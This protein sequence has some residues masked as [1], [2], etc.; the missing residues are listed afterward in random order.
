MISDYKLTDDDFAQYNINV[1][2]TGSAANWSKTKEAKS[3]YEHFMKA[4]RY[5]RALEIAVKYQLLNRIVQVEKTASEFY[6]KYPNISEA[7]EYKDMKANLIA[8]SKNNAS[9]NFDLEK[10]LGDK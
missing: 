1:N 2:K 7:T 10:I 3:E 5:S 9:P 4:G 6:S 8:E